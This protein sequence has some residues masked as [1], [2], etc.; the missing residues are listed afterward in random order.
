MSDPPNK[1]QATG[2]GSIAY[3]G[4]ATLFNNERAVVARNEALTQAAYRAEAAVASQQDNFA[5]TQDALNRFRAAVAIQTE[6]VPRDA[7]AVMG[8]S[9]GGG[10]GAH[11]LAFPLMRV[12]PGG[13]SGHYPEAHAF[14]YSA[15]AGSLIP[16]YERGMSGAYTPQSPAPAGSMEV[17]TPPKGGA[18]RLRNF[19]YKNKKKRKSRAKYTKR[20]R[21]KHYSRK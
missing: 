9:A 4:H 6:A 10:H 14:P 13:G 19:S 12:F 21:R 5:R 15:H 1:R 7:E 20:K 16:I 17:D 18:R 3:T 8:T 2:T 11:Q